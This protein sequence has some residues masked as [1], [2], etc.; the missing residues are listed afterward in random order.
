MISSGPQRAEKPDLS[1][2]NPA[3]KKERKKERGDSKSQT[4]QEAFGVHS[5]FL[6]LIALH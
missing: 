1:R 5:G 6:A 2:G 3:Q 4:D